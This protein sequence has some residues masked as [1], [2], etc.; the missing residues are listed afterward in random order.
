[1]EVI[2]IQKEKKSSKN[3][4]MATSSTVLKNNSYVVLKKTEVKLRWTL[5]YRTSRIFL[6]M[7]SLKK[8]K[9]EEKL[10]V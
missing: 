5:K 9:E 8:A 2:I 4:M 1:M 3:I 6:L 10:K 7:S